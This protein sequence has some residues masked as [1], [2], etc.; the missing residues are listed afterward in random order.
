M[1][2]GDL[3]KIFFK[4]ESKGVH[5][6]G[7]LGKAAGLPESSSSNNIQGKPWKQINKHANK[8]KKEKS[9]RVYAHLDLH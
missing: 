5:S 1:T 6:K 8:K 3:D 7:V 4:E 2:S 9:R